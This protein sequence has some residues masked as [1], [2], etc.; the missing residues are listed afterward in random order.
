MINIQPQDFHVAI[1]ALVTGYDRSL[2]M[3]SADLQSSQRANEETKTNLAEALGK[4]QKLE[5]ENTALRAKIEAMT[6]NAA[7]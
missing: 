2:A 4:A 5:D 6:N 3:M 1:S 7:P